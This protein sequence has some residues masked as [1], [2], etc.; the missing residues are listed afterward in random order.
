[1]T[2]Q[3]RLQKIALTLAAWIAISLT[4]VHLGIAESE[5][6]CAV[7]G[8][9]QVSPALATLRDGATAS[10]YKRGKP[11]HVTLTLRAGAEGVYLPDFFGPFQGT[12]THGF[13]VEVLTFQGRLADPNSA[14]CAYA[15][16]PPKI[17]YVRLR[18]R[19]SRTWST[20][21]STKSIARGRYCLYAEYLS[22]ELLISSAL[23]LPHD[24]ALVARG[25]ITAPPLLIE[26][27]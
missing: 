12:C 26:I 9:P 15:G 1:M 3:N 8:T 24:K 23:N 6:G 19:E 13:T 7:F 14:G 16:G 11:I 17:P 2:A 5:S 27:R 10:V 18:P 4:S 25:R 20:S 21:L 22:S